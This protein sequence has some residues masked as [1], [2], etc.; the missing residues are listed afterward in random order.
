MKSNRRP[1]TIKGYNQTLNR[2][3]DYAGYRKIKFNF[4]EVD[5][6]LLNDL[7]RYFEEVREYALN[8]IHNHIKNLKVFMKE[9]KERGL[10]SNAAH[11]SRRFTVKTEDT[12]KVYL[13]EE[14]LNLIR[15]V[16]LSKMCGLSAFETFSCFMQ[17]QV[18]ASVICIKS[19][20]AIL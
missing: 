6:S 15:Q 13:S 2:L 16:D 14:E 19:T 8:T 20:A 1:E 4:D 12:P 18:S 3:T 17:I 7:V 9:A 10:H 11:E 5:L